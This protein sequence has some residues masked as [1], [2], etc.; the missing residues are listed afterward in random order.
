[1]SKLYKSG[2]AG[3]RNDLA[4][5]AARNPCPPG[6]REC[7]DTPDVQSPDVACGFEDSSPSG[8]NGIMSTLAQKLSPVHHLL[9]AGGAQWGRL[10]D[11]PVALRFGPD[12]VEHAALSVLA[13]CDVSGLRKLGVKGPA[14]E[15][16]LREHGLEL[17]AAVYDALPLAN[18]GLVVR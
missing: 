10:G 3:Q 4:V 9:Q 14:A 13:L 17:P 11:R 18:G 15:G 5:Q 12:E 16:W 1:M 2:A 8:R 6:W 7:R